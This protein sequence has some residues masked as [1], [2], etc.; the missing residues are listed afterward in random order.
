MS[1]SGGR[2]ISISAQMQISAYRAAFGW[3]VL[4]LGVSKCAVFIEVLWWWID[5]STFEEGRVKRPWRK[6]YQLIIMSIRKRLQILDVWTVFI[7]LRAFQIICPFSHKHL[8]WTKTIL[9]GS[10]MCEDKYILI[11]TKTIAKLLIAARLVLCLNTY[12]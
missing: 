3:K 8:L 9:L 7:N 6:L 4:A 11:E 12:K 2:S 1:V 10:K 5:Y